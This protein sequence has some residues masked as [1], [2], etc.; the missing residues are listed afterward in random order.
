MKA[1]VCA[2][3]A[4]LL[5]TSAWAAPGDPLGPVSEMFPDSFSRP[6]P[7]DQIDVAGNASGEFVV[8][9][10]HSRFG[11]GPVYGRVYHADGSPRTEPVL[12]VPDPDGNLGEL[13]SDSVAMAPD[14]TFWLVYTKP[15][16]GLFGRSNSTDILLQR[17]S[18]DAEPLGAPTR[19]RRLATTSSGLVI[20]RLTAPPVVSVDSDGQALVAWSWMSGV[21]LGVGLPIPPSGY[22]I[23][24]APPMVSNVKL[25]IVGTDGRLRGLAKGVASAAALEIELFPIDTT[26]PLGTGLVYGPRLS[27]G[28]DGKTVLAW[29]RASGAGTVT[30]DDEF[31]QI[32][33][34]SYSASGRADGAVVTLLEGIPGQRQVQSLSAF[35]SGFVVGWETD[36]AAHSQR[37][38]ASGAPMSTA[39]MVP[40]AVTGLGLAAGPT[41]GHAW[42]YGV[43]PGP[44]MFIQEV[45][46]DLVD[47]TGI[48]VVEGTVVNTPPAPQ[49]RTAT[50]GRV[51][52]IGEDFVVAW[53]EAFLGDPEPPGQVQLRRLDGF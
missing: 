4:G 16:T 23:L 3:L 5:A 35:D 29:S 22:P 7:V 51:A 40:D 39:R 47:A 21:S 26:L 45:Q 53:H 17:F 1:I 41:G 14:G 33:A 10:Q 19:V 48:P 6:E 52:A 12:L 8:V 18:T 31:T 37:F 49:L 38:N 34:R 42:V 43:R 25:Q 32:E 9:S 27:H 50:G 20:S 2:A 11:G 24:G 46:T 30:L 15:V 13:G 28:P 44:M 36:D